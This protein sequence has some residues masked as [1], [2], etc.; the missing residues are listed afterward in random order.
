MIIIKRQEIRNAGKEIVEKE[1]S[2]TQLVEC[3]WC[4][5]YGK[6]YEDASKIKNTTTIPPFDLPYSWASTSQALSEGGEIIILKRCLHT[7][8]LY[9]IICNS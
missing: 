8:I 4:S 6:Q 3:R 7:H 5:H 2:Y 1:R 9:S